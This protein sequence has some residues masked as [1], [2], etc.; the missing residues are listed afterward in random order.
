MPVAHDLADLA[1]HP[2]DY[3]FVVLAGVSTRHI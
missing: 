3:P 1:D 2:F